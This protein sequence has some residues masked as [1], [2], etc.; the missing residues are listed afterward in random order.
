MKKIV[1]GIL[2][3]L[4][5]FSLAPAISTQTAK[6]STTVVPDSYP[7]SNDVSERKVGVKVGDWALYDVFAN[8]STNDPDSPVRPIAPNVTE[9][10]HYKLEVL[11]ISDTRITYR[12]TIALLNGTQ[13]SLNASTD[14]SPNYMEV[15]PPPFIAANL[16]AG[17][18]L[19]NSSSPIVINATLRKTYAGAEREANYANLTRDELFGSY[20]LTSKIETYWDRASGIIDE[21]TQYARYTSGNLTTKL[22]GHLVMKETNIWS[23]RVIAIID[24]K[25]GLDCITLEKGSSF[26]VNVTLDGVTNF[27]HGFQVVV[28]F[29]NTKVKCTAAWI[30]GYNPWMIGRYDPNFVF[31][32]AT[33]LASFVTI[34][35]SLG[36]LAV[37]ASTGFDIGQ[38]MHYVNITGRKL[39]YQLNFTAIEAGNSSLR[40]IISQPSPCFYV[41]SLFD[42]NNTL[43]SFATKDLSITATPP[44]HKV[45]KTRVFIMPFVLNLKS[46][47]RWITAFIILPKGYNITDVDFS[48]IKLNGTIAAERVYSFHTRMP[49]IIAKFD[50]QAVIDLIMSS[51][52][53]AKRHG[54]TRITLAISGKLVNGTAFEGNTEIW[55][56]WKTPRNGNKPCT[57]SFFFHNLG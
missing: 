54:F 33:F 49:F 45:A 57:S 47:G 12:M 36:C 17:D 18:K 11:E 35:N 6:T 14:V 25:T 41:T 46:Q 32:N 23:G 5:L 44:T 53:L 10:E 40:F 56:L 2:L 19:Y 16:T 20:R 38:L 43:L 29:D 1:V 9:I 8:Y 48:S 51:H 27:L 26:T 52:P 31:Y 39:L 50:R 4:V 55:I 30:N 13:I 28:A 37:G 22:Y 7:V 42:R 3:A 21:L 15:A 34:H 24:A